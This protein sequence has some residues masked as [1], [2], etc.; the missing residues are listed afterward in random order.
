MNEFE[1]IAAYNDIDLNDYQYQTQC[2]SGIDLCLYF[3]ISD[4]DEVM[5][6]SQDDKDNLYV[7]IHPHSSFLANTGLRIK[8][9]NKNL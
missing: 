8:F 2:S 1:L 4:I 3:D 5:H 9:N 6:W 7:M